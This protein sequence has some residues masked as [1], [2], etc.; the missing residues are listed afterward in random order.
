MKPLGLALVLVTL[1]L[2]LVPAPTNAAACQFVLGFK[3]VYDLIPNDVGDCK[4]EQHYNP[5]NGDALQETTGGLLVWRKADNFTA[6][7]DGYRTWV[8]GPYGLQQRLNTE[9]FAWEASDPA[10]V[11]RP[12]VPP[13]PVLP[14]RLSGCETGHWV[15]LVADSG[16][17][18]MLEDK[19]IW[20]VGSVDRLDSKYWRRR[21]NVVICESS[22]SPYGYIMINTDVGQTVG[23]RQTPCQTGHRI[24]SI[25]SGGRLVLLEDKSVWEV[26]FADRIY[27]MLWLPA[28]TVI[29]CDSSSSLYGFAIINTDDQHQVGA[30]PLS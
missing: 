17:I 16:R 26:D 12:T 10:P 13:A 30:R 22:S 28:S 15:S 6:F 5:Q 4:T 11:P 23:V 2:A 1:S 8:N 19:S 7:T 3:M 20:R 25:G 24:S 29:I 14:G 9:R 18:V 27:S 21:E